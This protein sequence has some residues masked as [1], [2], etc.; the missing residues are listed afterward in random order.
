[1][2]NPSQFH[3]ITFIVYQSKCIHRKQDQQLRGKFENYVTHMKLHPRQ[4]SVKSL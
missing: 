4:I 1:M 2:H 3:R